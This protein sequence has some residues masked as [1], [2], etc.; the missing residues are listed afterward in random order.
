MEE[1]QIFNSES[2]GE[3]RT[4]TINNEPMFCLMD[5]CK[6]LEIKNPTVVASRLEDDEVTKL[7]LGSK[8]GETN[9]VTESGMYAV[10]LR[11]DKK[12]A[13]EFRK[14]VTADILPTLRKTGAYIMPQ[15]TTGQIQLLAQ[16]HIE[17]E[18]RV[19]DITKKV[20]DIN[21]KVDERDQT[22][23]L[24]AV[25]CQ[26]ITIAKNKKVVGLMGGK[27]ANAYKNKSLRMRVYRDI[28]TQIRR[29]FGVDTYKAIHRN[30]MDK[31]LEIINSYNLPLCLS[32]EIAMENSQMNL[33][34]D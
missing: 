3:I 6:A 33:T 15:T 2:F 34:E 9:F 7:D 1:L 14:W 30:K 20:D 11:S 28:E 8:N 23:P 5:I 17:L 13:R 16:G 4:I 12:K 21:K 19:E 27:K 26:Y 10:V 18:Q 25:D 29:E 31:A 24:L 22:M 32:E